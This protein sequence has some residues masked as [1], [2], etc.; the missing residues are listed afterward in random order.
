MLKLNIS[1]CCFFQFCF[2]FL[3]CDSTVLLVWLAKHTWL[4]LG[5]HHVLAENTCLWSPKLQLEM[6]QCHITLTNVETQACN[7]VYIPNVSC[8]VSLFIKRGSMWQLH[9]LI[10]V[11]LAVCEPY[12]YFLRTSPT[13]LVVYT[14][15]WTICYRCLMLLD[16]GLLCVGRS[17]WLYTLS[18]WLRLSLYY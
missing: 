8:C 4:G 11:L 10:T 13:L 6:S 2:K 5:K 9:L 1:L 17:K 14:N 15:L 16:C 18:L 7:A 3:Y 12:C